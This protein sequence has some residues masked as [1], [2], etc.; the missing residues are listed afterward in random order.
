VLSARPAGCAL[1][2]R[3]IVQEDSVTSIANGGTVEVFGGVDSHR[4]TIHVAVVDG[5]GRMIADREFATT[6]EGYQDALGWLRGHG[7]VTGVGVEGTSS[8]GTGFTAFLRAEGV[9]VVEVDRPD[10]RARR[11][12]GKSD[13]LDA[14]AAA[15]AV[16]SG[17][18]RTVPKSH[19]GAAECIRVLQVTRASAVKART[20]AI[21][22]LKNLLVTAP[23]ALRESLGGHT[24]AALVEA[25]VRLRPG[26]ELADPASATKTALRRLAR[27][28]RALSE[29]ITEADA[30]LERLTATAAPA[31]RAQLGVGADV[32][33]TLLTAVGDNPERM[34]SEAAFAHLCGTAPIPASSGRTNRHRLNRGGNRQANRAIHV[35]ALTRM[36]HCERTRAYVQRRRREGLSTP[37]IMRC[38]KRYIARELFHVIT[39][40][41]RPAPRHRTPHTP[42][43]A[44]A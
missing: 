15:H 19:D 16:L 36:R 11:A 7:T 30:E 39:R 33:A 23:A 13:P 17:R 4:D 34:R 40:T 2:P 32:A 14:Y 24:G 43:P 3:F 37:E 9:P 35:V 42:T 38:L 21:N 22:Q 25:C 18:A 31:L 10:R 28:V 44:A 8:Y 6:V 26:A 1:P 5:L 12:A 27:R 29:E 41:A 20:Q